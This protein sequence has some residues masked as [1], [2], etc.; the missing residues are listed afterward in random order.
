MLNVLLFLA[1]L[2]IPLTAAMYSFRTS[3]EFQRNA[4]HY[5]P[6]D[7]NSRALPCSEH[8]PIVLILSQIDPVHNPR[9]IFVTLILILQAHLRLDPSNCPLPST[10][11]EIDTSRILTEAWWRDRNPSYSWLTKR[12]TKDSRNVHISWYKLEGK[13]IKTP[14][15]SISSIVWKSVWENV[16]WQS[17]PYGRANRTATQGSAQWHYK[18]WSS[19][20]LAL[21]ETRTCISSLRVPKQI[22]VLWIPVHK[23]LH[24]ELEFCW[25]SYLF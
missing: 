14:L 21:R 7:R 2:I 19:S 17:R 5:F 4:W 10:I 25:S 8:L 13:K 3:V 20:N 16:D 1:L 23:P 6:K 12:L 11:P 24:T 15:F 18:I 22:L 9:P